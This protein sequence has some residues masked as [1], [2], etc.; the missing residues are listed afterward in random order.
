[1]VHYH[2]REGADI[3]QG[4]HTVNGQPQAPRE[5]NATAPAAALI[6]VGGIFL[7]RNLDLLPIYSNWWALLLLVPLYFLGARI[8]DFRAKHGGSLPAAA[9]GAVTGFLSVALVMIIFLFGLDWG[10]VWPLFIILVG[11]SF[12]IG[13]SSGRRGDGAPPPGDP[14]P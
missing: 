6:I 11:V 8:L 7:L 9:R 12:L 2:A 3:D 10:E 1:V 5:R 4:D 14:N 13:G